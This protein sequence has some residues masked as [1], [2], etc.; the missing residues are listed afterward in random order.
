MMGVLLSRLFRGRNREEGQSRASEQDRA[1]L[2]SA[3]PDTQGVMDWELVTPNL[4]TNM[5]SPWSVVHVGPSPRSFVSYIHVGWAS[6]T[7]L[8]F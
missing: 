8:S 4:P 1:V 6:V 2:V 3:R 7:I 5:D